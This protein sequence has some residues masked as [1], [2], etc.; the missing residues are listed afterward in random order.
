MLD[1]SATVLS[2][3]RQNSTS[4]DAN[5]TPASTGVG[6]EFGGTVIFVPGRVQGDSLRVNNMGFAFNTGV[7]FSIINSDRYGGIYNIFGKAGVEIGNQHMFGFGCDFLAGTGRLPGD[8]VLCDEDGAE[9]DSTNP[10]TKWAFV[11]GVQ[12]WAKIGLNQVLR[13]VDLLTYIRLMR[14]VD[15]GEMF[16]SSQPHVEKFHNEG[17]SVGVLLRFRI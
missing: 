4:A 13:G 6:L 12:A 14:A 7:L 1:V 17:W 10:Y 3:K 11:Y 16:S 2:Q 8:I 9:T 5:N 15:S